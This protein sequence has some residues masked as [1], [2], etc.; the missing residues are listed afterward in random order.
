MYRTLAIWAVVIL[1]L[2]WL[3]SP[4]PAVA[5]DK[6]VTMTGEG[7]GEGDAANEDAKNDARR[8]ACEQ[9]VGVLIAGQTKVENF[10]VAMDMIV[11]KVKGIVKK[12][13]ILEGPTYDKA[14]DIT[15]IK[16]EITVGEADLKTQWAEVEMTLKRMGRPKLMI[17]ISD[18][19]DD[20]TL[21]QRWTET[22][23][24]NYFIE[25]GFEL[26][27]K[28]SFDEKMKREASSASLK[29]DINV[30]ADIGKKVG[31]QLVIRGI[32]TATKQGEM[33]HPTLDQML[34]NYQGELTI[35]AVETSSARLLLQKPF[36]GPKAGGTNNESAAKQ[37]LE[38][39]AKAVA[40]QVVEGII[41][42]WNDDLN[43]G[44]MITVIF[45]N[46]SFKQKSALQTLL[47]KLPRVREVNVESYTSKV[48]TIRVKTYRT[49]DDLA[50]RLTKLKAATID[51][52]GEN[53]EVEVESSQVSIKLP[54]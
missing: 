47:A 24:S 2:L 5:E 9:A 39:V 25:Q 21:E 54:G 19:V 45:S 53:V 38:K 41:K 31:A 48:A 52:T 8:K 42:A 35:K 50:E 36:T 40:P 32:C 14:T 1:A 20:K 30:L 49:A 12:E 7:A 4:P 26:V 27:D 51:L 46:I 37:A 17:L 10:A 18:T 15:T 13:K 11:T 22:S 23:I 6:V 28:D 43:N 3:V 44:R 16:M 29:G 34:Y 33:R